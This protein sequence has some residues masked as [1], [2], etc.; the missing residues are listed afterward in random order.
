MGVKYSQLPQVE[1]DDSD[2][3]SSSRGSSSK[4]TTWLKVYTYLKTKFDLVYSAGSHTHTGAVQFLEG[5]KYS[6]VDSGTLG[7]ISITDDYLYVCVKTGTSGNAIWKK[8]PMFQS[9]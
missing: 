4:G 3:I 2:I 6:S 9:L 7:Q 5:D 1:P 8:L